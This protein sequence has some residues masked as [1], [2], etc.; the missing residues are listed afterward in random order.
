MRLT[1][2]RFWSIDW[3]NH[4]YGLKT[5]L[6]ESGREE[7]NMGSKCGGCKNQCGKVAEMKTTSEK[8]CTGWVL[9][10]TSSELYLNFE[11]NVVADPIYFLANR[12]WALRF[13]SKEEAQ[14][15]LAKVLGVGLEVARSDILFFKPVKLVKRT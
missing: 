12:K 13:E 8:V 9:K 10:E 14:A 5:I 11:S 1:Q 15:E 2:E 6:K 3:F 7:N 4:L